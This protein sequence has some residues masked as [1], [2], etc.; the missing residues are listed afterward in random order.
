M[1]RLTGHV[2]IYVLYI[3]V[4][5]KNV[6][7]PLLL[8]LLL[9]WLKSFDRNVDNV[10]FLFHSLAY[11]LPLSF[12]SFFLF[13]LSITQQYFN[14]FFELIHRYNLFG[15]FP[16]WHKIIVKRHIQHICQLPILLYSKSAFHAW[17][18][19]TVTSAAT[20]AASTRIEEEEE[21]E[22]RKKINLQFS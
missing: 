18:I 11:S 20:T 5:K 8:L 4:T 9:H 13:S 16:Q 7:F 1:P 14:R 21:E 12:F 22:N 19:T 2:T 6:I 17:K 10:Q 3:E 15:I